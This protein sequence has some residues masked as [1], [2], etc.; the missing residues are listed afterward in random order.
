MTPFEENV[1]VAVVGGL[2]SAGLLTVIILRLMQLKP[3]A[4]VH[5]D[6]AN[7]YTP[8]ILKPDDST[9]TET[10]EGVMDETHHDIVPGGTTGNDSSHTEPNNA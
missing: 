3:M 5:E 6:L 9:D 1:F 7:Y 4:K 10:K 2:I 8:D